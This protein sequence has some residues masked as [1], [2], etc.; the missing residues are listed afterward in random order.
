MGSSCPYRPARE[1]PDTPPLGHSVRP[2]LLDTATT[3]ARHRTKL[4]T[5]NTRHNRPLAALYSRD[6]A[7]K[8][9]AV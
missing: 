9:R 2:H 8:Q 6:L 3:T 7:N 4:D 1:Q 5:T